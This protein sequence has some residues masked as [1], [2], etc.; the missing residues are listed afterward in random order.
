MLGA[1]QRI[2]SMGSLCEMT[3][4]S[5]V[6]IPHHPL[7]VQDGGLCDLTSNLHISV[8]DAA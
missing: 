2:D 4:N 5:G 3:T 8:M 6:P 7:A 1:L